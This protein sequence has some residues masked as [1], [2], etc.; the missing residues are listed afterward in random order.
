MDMGKKLVGLSVVL[1]SSLSW[2]AEFETVRIVDWAG[3]KAEYAAKTNG[4]A[5]PHLVKVP[6]CYPA[7]EARAR[8]EA[9]GKRPV[10]KPL[11]GDEPGLIAMVKHGLH[12]KLVLPFS[13]HSAGEHNFWIRHWRDENCRTALEFLLRSPTANA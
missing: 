8:R 13:V 12:A 6:W 5:R 11:P 9:Q 4:N 10:V 2:G 7:A 3:V 1:L